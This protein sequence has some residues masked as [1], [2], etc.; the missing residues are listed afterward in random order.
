M[1][2]DATFADPIL[3]RAGLASARTISP[4]ALPELPKGFEVISS[5][6]HF[7]ITKDIFVERFPQ[8]LKEAAPRVWFD[9][10]WRMGFPGAM[11]A[12]GLNEEISK[13]LEKI[14]LFSGFD[15]DVRAEHMPLEGVKAEIVYPQSILGFIRHPDLEVRELLFRTYNEYV[16]E[17]DAAYPG[18][19][20]G[21]GVCSNWW[22]PAKAESAI[23]QI[24]DLRLKTYMI[25]NV[26][27]KD[28]KGYAH[29]DMERFWSVVEGAGLPVAY[30]V[31][32]LPLVPGRGGLGASF[33]VNV[34]PFRSTFGQL[35]FGGVYDRHPKLQIVFAEGGINWVA[36]ALQD[37]EMAIDTYADSYDYLP[38]HRPSYYWHNHCYA[39][40]QTD[41]LGMRLL[42][43]IGA[44]RVMWALDYPHSEGTFGLHGS[45]IK[46]V[47]QSTSLENAKKILGD[48][49]RRLYRLP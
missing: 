38:K 21:V 2:D 43:L 45:S 17:V 24:V 10:Y 29:T 20:H 33:V 25:P 18:R 46:A 5:D 35:I 9:G 13:F 8:R 39:T 19:F 47:L 6:N 15:L 27:G 26:L 41:P 34:A 44:D 49:A 40:F 36:G 4:V 16:A 22:D 23:R 31:G 14:T 28:E 32:E 7:E 3:K 48:T 11:E 42:D 30:H 1:D 12:L 37:A